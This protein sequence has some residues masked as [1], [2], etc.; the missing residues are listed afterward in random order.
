MRVCQG[1]ACRKRGSAGL[2]AALQESGAC[3]DSMAACKC[4]DKCKAGPNV[5][6]RAPGAPRALLT[7]VRPEMVPSIMQGSAQKQPAEQRAR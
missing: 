6:V 1:K 7:G 2:M 4:L 3:A 5:S